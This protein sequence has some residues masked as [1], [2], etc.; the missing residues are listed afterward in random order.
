MN[1]VATAL[2]IAAAFAAGCSLTHYLQE[3]LA[4]EPMM[5]QIIHTADMEGDALGT[6]NNVGYRNKMFAA[7]DGWR[8]SR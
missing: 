4:A 2:S 5:A 8:S 6:A 3:A 7:A 1:R